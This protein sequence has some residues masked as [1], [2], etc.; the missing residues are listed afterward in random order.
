MG[1]RAISP[2][3]AD[4]DVKV[5]IEADRQADWIAVPGEGLTEACSHESDPARLADFLRGQPAAAHAFDVCNPY[6]AL[7]NT[8]NGDGGAF[9]RDR[10][11]STCDPCGSHPF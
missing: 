2:E 10:D 9:R 6:P 11:V 8:G 3:R 5:T 4:D 7:G 1:P